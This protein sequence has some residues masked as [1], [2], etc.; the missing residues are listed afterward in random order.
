MP[1]IFDY[2]CSECG[3]VFEAMTTNADT[4]PTKCKSCGSETATFKKFLVGPAF[5]EGSTPG[6]RPP[7]YGKN[8]NKKIDHPHE[9]AQGGGRLK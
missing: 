6:S 1:V 8:A 7:T 4:F 9:L 5:I 2:Q 3:K